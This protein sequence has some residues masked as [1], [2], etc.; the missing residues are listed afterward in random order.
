MWSEE[1]NPRELPDRAS[2]SFATYFGVRVGAVHPLPALAQAEEP[3]RGPHQEGPREGRRGGRGQP[4]RGRGGQWG[5]GRAA[6]SPLSQRG[7][8]QARPPGALFGGG[9]ESRVGTG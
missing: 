7:R 1:K 5:G 2:F 6:G 9:V 8:H 3:V 4:Y